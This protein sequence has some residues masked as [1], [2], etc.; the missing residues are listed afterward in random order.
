M[1]IVHIHP[2]GR[3]NAEHIAIIVVVDLVPTQSHFRSSRPQARGMSATG[4]GPI[5]CLGP[6]LRSSALR[7]SVTAVMGTALHRQMLLCDLTS[8][9]VDPDELSAAT[10]ET[11]ARRGSGDAAPCL[12]PPILHPAREEHVANVFMVRYLAWLCSG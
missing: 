10:H 11:L 12:G 1:S 3:W 6:E 8:G 9:H 7:T 2:E 4:L 5:K